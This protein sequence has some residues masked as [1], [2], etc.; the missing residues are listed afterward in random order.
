M[1]PAH[2]AYHPSIGL[3]QDD[4]KISSMLLCSVDVTM[5]VHSHVYSDMGHYTISYCIKGNSCAKG[6]KGAGK[7]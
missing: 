2:V 6:L 5:T 1:C 4:L 7:Y 3:Q